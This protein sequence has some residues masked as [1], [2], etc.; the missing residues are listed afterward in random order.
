MNLTAEMP[1]TSQTNPP[2]STGAR[3]ILVVGQFPPPVHGF[4]QATL[5]VAELLEARGLR[6]TRI[7]LKPIKHGKTFLSPLVTR[8][9]QLAKAISEVRRG[10]PVYIGLSGGLRQAVDFVF[11]TVGRLGRASLFVHHHNFTYL[12]RPSLLTRMCVLVSG[13]SAT[14][15]VLCGEMKAALQRRYNAAR[16]VEIVSNAGLQSVCLEFRHRTTVRRIGYLSALTK[17]KGI[18]E[19]LNAAV[20][21]VKQHPELRFS[22]AGPCRDA[23]IREEVECACRNNRFIDYAGPVYGAAKNAFVQSLDLLL[24]PTRNDAEPLVI[25]EAM[26]SGI[27]VIG[28]ERG[29]I[30]EMLAGG[31]LR[32]A[33]ISRGSPFA[34][35]AVAKIESWLSAPELYSHRSAAVRA[36]FER[37]STMSQQTFDRIFS[38]IS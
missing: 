12:D 22:I 38:R 36:Q 32:S 35:T 15:I 24:F 13:N 1:C 19:F 8:F 16:N 18:L 14:H 9:S 20:I 4:A 3:G 6:V 11:L 7:D 33:V 30:G 10:S 27:P 29:C 23:S 2:D 37:M 26:S 17:E 21:L 31:E 34:E 28:W 5:D 25:W